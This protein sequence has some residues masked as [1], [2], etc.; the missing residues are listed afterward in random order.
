MGTTMEWVC[1]DMGF[2]PKL[3]TGLR[4]MWVKQC[5]KPSMTGN[6]LYR[7]PPIKML[8]TGGWL[9]LFYPH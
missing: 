5:Q 7:I 1:A 9:L 6:G 3:G 2:Y 8:M 4:I